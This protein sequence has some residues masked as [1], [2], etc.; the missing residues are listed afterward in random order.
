MQL[1]PTYLCSLGNLG[2]TRMFG[3][4]GEGREGEGREKEARG[5]EPIGACYVGARGNP[6]GVCAHI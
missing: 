3:E 5:W 2:D 6:G 1:A 4:M